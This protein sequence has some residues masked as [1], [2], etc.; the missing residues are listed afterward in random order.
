MAAPR[1][2]NL[3]EEYFYNINTPNKAYILGFIYADGSINK[4]KNLTITLA[5]KDIDI[6]LFI[7]DELN[8]QGKIHRRIVKNRIYYTLNITSKKL[9]I[10]LEN[11]GIIPNKTYLS[12]S[13]P[14]VDEELYNHFLRGIFDGDGS[15][16]KCKNNE[17][18]VCFSSNI[19]VLEEI[20]EFLNSIGILT[21][22]IRLRNKE[23]IFS[24]MLEIRGSF[25]IEKF[26]K[27]LYGKGGFRLQRKYNIFKEAEK[28]DENLLKRRYTE[29]RINQIERLYN[30]GLKQ[31]EIYKELNLPHSSVRNVVQRL[32]KLNRVI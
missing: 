4:E 9:V 13:L 30:Q 29:D 17:Y 14:I 5:E 2:Y 1:K 18:T 21:S 12:K 19:Y 11:N 27:F 6:L 16:Y 22:N 8:Y 32:R 26:K 25:K 3:D 23:S 31:C 7:K 15:I 24:G 20:K 28:R 10:S